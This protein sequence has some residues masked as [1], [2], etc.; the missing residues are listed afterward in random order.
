MSMTIDHLT[1]LIHDLL[2][3]HDY[4]RH[5]GASAAELER[6]QLAIGHLLLSRVL[7]VAHARQSLA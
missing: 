1:T 4:R 2:G 3:E 5:A 7:M 6:M